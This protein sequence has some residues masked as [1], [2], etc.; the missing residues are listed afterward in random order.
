MQ[1][2]HVALLLATGYAK[3]EDMCEDVCGE[4]SSAG[5]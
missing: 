3:P 2:C 4:T 5:R 1:P